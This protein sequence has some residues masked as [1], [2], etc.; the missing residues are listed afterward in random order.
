MNQIV[1]QIYKNLPDFKT[2]K[3]L[4]FITIFLLAFYEKTSDIIVNSAVDAYIAVT[5]FVAATV[6]IFYFFEK[7]NLN[8]EN[9]FFRYKNFQIF[10]AA[11]LGAIPGCGGAIIVVSLFTKKII[12]FSCVLAALISTMGDAAFLL[13]ASKPISALTI[14]SITFFTSMISAYIFR[15]LDKFFKP[16]EITKSIDFNIPSYKMNKSFYIFWMILIVPGIFLGVLNAFQI[17]PHFN[18][19]DIVFWVGI[20]GASLSL[21]I[22]AINPLTDIQMNAIKENSLK[23]CVDLTCFI[24]TWVIVAFLCYELIDLAS[25]GLIWSKLIYYGPFIPLLAVLIGFIPG[26]GPQIMIT[27]LYIGGQ[28]PLSAQLANAISNDGDALF[29]AI[30]L[31][32]KVA[33]YATLISSIPALIVGYFWY[34]FI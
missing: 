17:A 24:T 22:W 1:L 10:I 5:S 30:A 9:L 4:L 26:C 18:G 14:I 25:N 16:K 31:S 15:F 33:I 11:I 8:I 2:H 19:I 3:L 34:I 28:I 6:F 7:R 12:P 32:P 27:S 20:F 29:P 13:I 21:L 23:K